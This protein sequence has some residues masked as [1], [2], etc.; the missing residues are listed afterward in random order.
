M[1]SKNQN[2]SNLFFI[3]LILSINV[4]LYHLSTLAYLISFMIVNRMQHHTERL[5][6]CHRVSKL[7]GE[8]YAQPE[9]YVEDSSAAR[10]QTQHQ[11]YALP[12]GGE[13]SALPLTRAE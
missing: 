8:V 5:P 11:L 2:Q 1:L 9:L 7:P 12:S 4:I 3:G 6:R 10:Q 13:F